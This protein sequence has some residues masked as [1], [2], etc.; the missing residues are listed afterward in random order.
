MSDHMFHSGTVESNMYW[1]S[2]ELHLKTVG[3]GYGYGETPLHTVANY[4]VGVS[5]FKLWQTAVKADVQL[6]RTFQNPAKP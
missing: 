2:D 1:K 4:A 6:I 3:Y 5:Y